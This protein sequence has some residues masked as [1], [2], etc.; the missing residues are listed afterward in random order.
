MFSPP[1]SARP[2]I[3]LK[4]D[5]PIKGL[6]LSSPAALPQGTTN[7]RPVPAHSEPAVAV[8]LGEKKGA[9]ARVQLYPLSQLVAGGGDP[10]KTENRDLPTA[11][12]RKAFY[13]A[14]KLSVKWNKAG[15]MVCQRFLSRD[16][17]SVGDCQL[18][19]GRADACRRFSSHIPTWTPRASRTTARRIFTLS[20]S[21]ARSMASSTSVSRIHERVSGHRSHHADKE[22][23]IYD[24]CW[25]PTSREF[26]VCYGC[27][28]YPAGRS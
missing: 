20:A 25:S 5:A 27:E 19:S 7:A 2:S 15:T 28:W 6:F 11:L 21:T 3:R 23:P 4:G 22:G 12:A 1:L 24:F 9:P 8:W 16:T 13:K 18:F 10:E 14:D 26:S 17:R